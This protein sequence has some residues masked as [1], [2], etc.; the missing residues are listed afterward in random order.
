MKNNRIEKWVKKKEKKRKALNS[1][2]LCANV[3]DKVIRKK[4]VHTCRVKIG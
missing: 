2:E 3:D 1:S 4:I